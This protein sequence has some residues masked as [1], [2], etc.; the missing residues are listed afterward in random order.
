M[1]Q[2]TVHEVAYPESWGDE[3]ALEQRG[4]P[5]AA[6]RVMVDVRD[7]HKRYGSVRALDGVSFGVAEG[8]IFGL[9]GHNGAGKT[10]TI[11]ILTGQT[12]PSSGRVLVAG[13]DP[14]HDREKI[15]PLVNLV[16]DEQ[17]L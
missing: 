5:Q 14:I 7:L 12:R 13:F 11:R 17:N 1:R 16:F 10:T 8:E 2:L 4:A 6:G 9:Q 15:K 3:R